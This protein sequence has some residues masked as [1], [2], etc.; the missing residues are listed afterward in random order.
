MPRGRRRVLLRPPRPTDGPELVTLVKASREFLRPWAY[1]PATLPA[2]RKYLRRCRGATYRGLLLVR[3]K[4]GA[5]LGSLN[6]S[7]IFLGNFRSAYL[8]YWVGGPHAGEGYMREGMELLLCH[9]FGKL[10]LHRVEANVQPRNASSRALVRR[11]G[12]RKEGFSPRYLKVGGRWRDHERWAITAED[13]K[14]K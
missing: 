13:W 10:G 1:P 6:L 8:G 14:R 12:F 9:A 4:D 2:F 7:Q 3:R 11:F 5:I